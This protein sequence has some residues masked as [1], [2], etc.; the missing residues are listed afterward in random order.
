MTNDQIGADIKPWGRVATLT[1][2]LFA[3]LAGQF[4]GLAVLTWYYGQSLRSLP[5]L[6]GDGVAVTLIIFVATVVQVSLLAL[7][8][9]MRRGDVAQYLGLKLPRR[10]D[11]VFGIGLMIAFIIIGNTLSWVLGRGIITSFQSDIFRTAR[12]AGWLPWLLIAVV[13]VTP[14]SEELLFRGFLFH[15][16]LRTP[17]D[18]W[19]VIVVTALLFAI[20]HVQYDWY[21]ISHVFV[22]GLLQGWLRWVTGST[23]LTI[24]LHAFV[25]MEGMLETFI[26][27]QWQG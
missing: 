6:S 27:L 3:L 5:N 7:F 18:T 17:R 12:A 9:Q 2:G 24:L 22:F 4:A 23:L 26:S 16:W 19:P 25:N 15:G 10:A 8:V 1:L 21:I 13:A 20:M 11:V 14:V